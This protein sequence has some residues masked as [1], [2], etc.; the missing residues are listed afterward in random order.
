ME[1]HVSRH[2]LLRAA[3][4]GVSLEEIKDV[5]ASGSLAPAGLGRSAREKVYLFR[6]S[7][8]GRYYEQK[9]VKV[10]FVMEKDAV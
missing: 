2:T 6:S 7:W 8:Q 5:V 9:K 3:K 4:R 10:V 1:L